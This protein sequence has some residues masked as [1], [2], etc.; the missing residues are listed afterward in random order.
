MISLRKTQYDFWLRGAVKEE[1]AEGN[2]LFFLF[3]NL[4]ADLKADI[5][6]RDKEKDG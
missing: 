3:D 1:M 6:K 2:S 5:I 4:I